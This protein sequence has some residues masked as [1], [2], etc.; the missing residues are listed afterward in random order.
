LR[1]I[2]L[3][4]GVIINYFQVIAKNRSHGKLAESS[5]TN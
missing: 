3:V 1:F 5:W 4:H 2:S